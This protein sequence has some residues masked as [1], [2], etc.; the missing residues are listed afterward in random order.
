MDS[1][2]PIPISDLPDLNPDARA[3]VR[4]AHLYSTE[5]LLEHSR[6]ACTEFLETTAVLPNA[7]KAKRAGRAGA[8]GVLLRAFRD[9]KIRAG[10]ALFDTVAAEYLAIDRDPEAYSRRLELVVR[11]FVLQWLEIVRHDRLIEAAISAAALEWEAQRATPTAPPTS[12]ARRSPA[13]VIDDFRRRK[14]W[15]IDELVAQADVNTNQIYKIKHEKPVWTTTIAKVARALGCPPGD[16]IN[17]TPPLK[18]Q[19]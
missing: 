2:W 19:R 18:S 16:L 17:T 3:R 6:A 9:A 7:G 15:T 11:P 13:E 10:R 12:P 5:A 1:S 8:L 14:G 4:A